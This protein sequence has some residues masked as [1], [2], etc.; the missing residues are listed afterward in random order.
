MLSFVKLGVWQL[1]LSSWEEIFRVGIAL[2][3]NFPGGNCPGGSYPGWKFSEWELSWVGIFQVG[4]IL[5]GNFLWWE[6]SGCELPG[7]N[8]PGGNFPGRS[9]HD[10]VSYTSSGVMIT[11]Y[12]EFFEGNLSWAIG[13]QIVSFEIS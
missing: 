9:F 4:V 5:D 8:H 12:I 3:G 6:F 11:D 1:I 10:T 2:G 7:R 13:F